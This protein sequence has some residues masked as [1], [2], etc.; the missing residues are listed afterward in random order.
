MSYIFSAANIDYSPLSI[1]LEFNET[2]SELCS[3]IITMEDTLYENDETLSVMLTTDDTA[4]TLMPS[5]LVVTIEDDDA[6]KIMRN[7][8][9]ICEFT[10]KS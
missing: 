2:T 1:T 5:Q 3:Y 10:R 6:G 9:A 8:P 7:L 4:V